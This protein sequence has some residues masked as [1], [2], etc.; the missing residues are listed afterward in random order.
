M[1]LR[2]EYDDYQDVRHNLFLYSSP[3][4][5][6]AGFLLF[7]FVLP[8]AHQDA[9]TRWQ[10]TVSTHPLWKGGSG[11]AVLVF[12]T[13]LLVEVVKIHDRFYD[14]HL[15]RWRYRYDTDFILPRLVLPFGNRLDY[16]FFEEAEEHLG[17]FMEEL[18][19]PF[20][21]DRDTK[22]AKNKLVRFYERV[23][24]YWL[25]QMN[26]LVLL[27]LTVTIA[28]YYLL[29]PD[30]LAFKAQLMVPMLVVVTLFVLNRR[31]VRASREGTRSATEDEIR[32]IVTDHKEDLEQ[33][34]RSVCATYSIPFN[35]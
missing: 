2:F 17:K 31:L 12:L 3:V 35:D 14:K 20:V 16:R 25:T 28:A 19:Y 30:Q 21:G 26:E 34:L 1:K 24:A 5:I 15:V 23:T 7:F 10:E 18:W 33:R 27:L 32:A 6:A 13:Y 4:L 8:Q 22:I 29:G 9:I 11:L